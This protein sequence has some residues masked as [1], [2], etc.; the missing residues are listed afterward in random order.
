VDTP[1]N[2]AAPDRTHAPALRVVHVLEDVLLA[3]SLGGILV[4][5]LLEILLR[6]VFQTGFVGGNSLTQ[7]F[8][9]FVSMFGGAVAA[10]EA[11]LLTISQGFARLPA[12]WGGTS[13]VV[14]A[15]VSAGVAAILAWAGW[16]F[17]LF[18]RE[19]G[20]VFAWGIPVWIPQVA[21]TFGFASIAIRLVLGAGAGWKP[22]A[23]SG[24]LAATLV[25]VVLRIEPESWTPAIALLVLLLAAG[26][27]GAPI[28][29][30]LGGAAVF[31]F[32]GSYNPLA[33]IALSHYSL[34]T[35]PTIP[36]LP[37]FTLA[38]YF[39]AEGGTSRRMVNLLQA[40]VGGLR[41]GPAL[42][43]VAA[44]GFFTSLTGA[45]GVTI[46]ALGGL[47]VPFLAGARY[48]E[49]ASIGLVT[50]AGSI[51]LLF[52]PCLPLILYAIIAQV[53]I[54]SMFL[55]GIGP[56]LLLAGVVVVWAT[57]RRP[58]AAPN[59]ETAW[60]FDARR[61]ATAL[62][63]AKWE[64]L[65]PVVSLGG[66]FSGLTTPVEAAAV[67]ALYAFVIEAFVYRDLKLRAL[68]RVVRECGLLIGGVLLILGVAQAFTNYLID[69]QAPSYLVDL[70][71]ARVSS[72]LV[73]LALLTI[74]L[75]V[76]GCVMDVFSAIIVVVP[77]IVPL[78]EAFGIDPLHLGVFF[79]ANLG[80]GYLTPPVGMNLF[81]ASYRFG[82]PM[83]EVLRASL[84]YF[85]LQLVAV[86]LI[87]FWPT[88]TLAIP[89]MFGY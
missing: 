77:L 13:E 73:F 38:G 56:G 60:K 69:A 61:A 10:R 87:A 29:V 32:W 42:V 20:R 72:P 48:E 4:L 1:D 85:W 26:V 30:L 80:L 86:L 23:V 9:L 68:P 66:I 39:L 62:W 76:V 89:R 16:E 31:L 51:G 65:I 53:E 81:L 41:A 57:I 49:R 67:T 84:P 17:L 58:R 5:P 22:R 74:V 40:T 27:L 7:H 70:V 55:G 25:F 79:L 82:K 2:P 75:L 15:S 28:F 64:L 12:P 54:R 46:L 50:G 3:I 37:L 8:T 34:S 71:T 88:L 11:R 52:A 24:A 44:C 35:N 18:E 33:S 43:T 6:S 36:A 14:R 83:S 21:I 63:E 78:G 45:S 19:G 47:L 59:A